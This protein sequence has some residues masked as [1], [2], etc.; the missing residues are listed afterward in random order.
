[1]DMRFSIQKNFIA[2]NTYTL[3]SEMGIL[4]G[5]P[6]RIGPNADLYPTVMGTNDTVIARTNSEGRFMTALPPGLYVLYNG[7][8]AALKSNIIVEKGKVTELGAF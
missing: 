6:G 4:T 7:T 8:G 5:I 1:G 2:G 3:S